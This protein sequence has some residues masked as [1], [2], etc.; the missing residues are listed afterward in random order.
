MKCSIISGAPDQNYQFLKEN[1]DLNSFII[2]ADSGYLNCKKA[3]IPVN[4]IIGDFDSS[5]KPDCF[6][7]VIALPKEKDDTDTFSC[8]KEAIKR[9]Y[10]EIVLYCALGS[11]F[12][13]TY[14]NVICLDYCRRNGVRAYIVNDKNK[15]MLCDSEIVFKKNNYK[16]FS[17]FAFS[18]IIEGLSIKGAKY[19][20][21]NKTVYSW[22][23]FGQSNEFS[24]CEV[25]I[26]IKKGTILLIFSN[27]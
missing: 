8:I 2:A 3:G 25:K 4:L 22:Q 15:I 1:I 27:D 19:C 14:S 18:D 11:R 10:D 21:D 7:E 26:S 9:G 6:C 12:D 5:D 20:L 16:Y 13:H 23:S 24:D 17:V